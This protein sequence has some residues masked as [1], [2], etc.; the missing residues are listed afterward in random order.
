MI[1]LDNYYR[2][3]EEEIELVKARRYFDENR[4]IQR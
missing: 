1:N 4:I 2:I 3:A